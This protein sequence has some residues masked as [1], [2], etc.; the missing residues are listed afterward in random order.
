MVAYTF[1]PST[2]EEKANGSE[3]SARLVYIEFQGS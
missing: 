1:N 2:Q 3:I